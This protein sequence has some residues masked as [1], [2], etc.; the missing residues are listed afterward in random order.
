MTL[1]G[2]MTLITCT[3]GLYI[4]VEEEFEEICKLVSKAV[5]S[6]GWLKLT[7][8]GGEPIAVNLSNVACF[9]PE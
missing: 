8:T 1:G 2:E 6:S 7:E 9:E 3:E 4:K 5:E